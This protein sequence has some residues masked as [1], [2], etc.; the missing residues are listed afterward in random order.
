MANQDLSAI[1]RHLLSLANP[2]L[3]QLQ[4]EQLTLIFQQLFTDLAVGHS[5]SRVAILMDELQLNKQQIKELLSASGLAS[6]YSSTP[7]NL[8]A[9]PVS[10]LCVD[11]GDDLVYLS[12]YLAYEL[13]LAQQVAHLANN[14]ATYNQEAYQT[15]CVKLEQLSVREN[16]PNAEQLT[17]ILKSASQQFSIITGG[18]GTGKTTTVTLL[19]WLFYQIYG[20]ELKVKVCAP[21]GKAAVR[22]RES[23]EQS[24]AGLSSAQDLG[25][26]TECFNTLLAEQTNFGTL[27]KLLGYIPQ[28]IYFRH[29][30]QN[31]LD[32]EILIVDES[33]MVGLPLFSKLLAALDLTKLRH[34]VL[35]GDKNQ[36]SS[37]EEGYV[38]ASLV[39]LRKISYDPK[40]Y[41][42]FAHTEENLAAELCISNRNQGEIYALSQ[43]LLTQDS[44]GVTKVFTNAEQV[45]LYPAK[46]GNILN[47]LFDRKVNPLL[48][49]LDYAQTIQEVNLI[50]I[51]QLFVQLNQQAVLCLTNRGV[52]GCDNLNLQIERRIKQQIAHTDT[53]Y[54]G[55]PIIILQNDYTLELF[56]GDIGICLLDGDKVQIVFENGRQFIPEVLPAHGLAY[57]ITIHKSQGSEYGQVNLVL[58]EISATSEGASLLSREL[59]YTGVTR[60]KQR[61]TIFS[62]QALIFQAM[63]NHI[64][65]NTGLNNFL[66]L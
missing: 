6:V 16:K 56:N 57:A 39:N 59:V 37:V 45:Q 7:A 66:S 31:L 52:L 30:A 19:L 49:Y 38:F 51:K 65:R 11:S 27:H 53:W 61:V 47:Y 48:N 50:S 63:G 46:L 43:A 62:S 18:P 10:Y 5:C 25:I 17:A 33:S 58:P 21:T 20:T 36:L 14:V 3:G 2:D 32:V 29:N 24:I 64:Q 34:I 9:T 55:R 1:S 26:S 54:S 60:A 13:G 15:A 44:L 42:L 8:Q 28:S 23:I 40:A 22:V 35:L 4:R 41:D 12:K